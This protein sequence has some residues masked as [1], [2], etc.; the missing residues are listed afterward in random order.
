MALVTGRTGES[1]QVVRPAELSV[2]CDECSLEGTGA[3]EDCLVT[4]LLADESNAVIVDV[5][6]ARAMRMLHRV[7]LLPELRFER[8]VG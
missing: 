7:G 3:C 1:D 6:E 4:F 2:S 5:M 8:K